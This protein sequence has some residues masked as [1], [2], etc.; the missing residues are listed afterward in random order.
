MMN[1]ERRMRLAGHIHWH[2]ELVANRLLL[3]EPNHGVKSWGR[4]AMTYVDSVWS[5]TGLSDT[6][7]IGGPTADRDSTSILGR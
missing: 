2:P 7:E 5:D 4:P 1:Q 3:S 6:G